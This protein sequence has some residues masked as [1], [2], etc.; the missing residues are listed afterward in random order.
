MN[1]FDYEFVVNAPVSAVSDFHHDTSILKKLTPPPIFIQT[2]RFDPLAEGATAELTMWFGP[3]PVPWTAVHTNVSEG[4][5]TDTQHHGPLKLWQHTHRFIPQDNGHT[6]VKEHIEYAY[7]NGLRGW[8]SRLMFNRA[9][10]FI[11]FSARKWLT[12]WHVGRMLKT[13]NQSNKS[14]NNKTT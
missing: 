10:L 12:R 5:F 7:N 1:T 14:P 3:I 2:H 11:L 4:G 9:S 8:F 6:L 13:K